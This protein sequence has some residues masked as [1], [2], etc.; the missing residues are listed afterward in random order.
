MITTKPLPKHETLRAARL[1]AEAFMTDPVWQATG[2]H[3][4]RHRKMVLIQFYLAEILIAYVRKGYVNGAYDGE[5]LVGAIIAFTDGREGTPWWGWLPRFVP[6][7]C[8]GP[9]AGGKAVKIAFDLQKLQPDN[10]HAHFW[11]VCA[12]EGTRG[13]GVLLMRSV[14][15]VVD[16]TRRPAYLE[17]TAPHLVDLYA[18]LGFAAQGSYV[19]PTGDVVTT[20][21][22]D[23]RAGAQV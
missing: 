17:A 2:P 16:S 20:M 14:L 3:N 5:R 10:D 13:V 6:V 9:V 21:W 23:S 22:R 15:D 19:L 12:A 18:L 8:A 7:A 11:Q 4:R 1:L